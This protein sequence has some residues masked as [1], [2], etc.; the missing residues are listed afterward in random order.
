[1]VKLD[2]ADASSG[3][4]DQDR[5][6][7]FIIIDN[8]EIG[9]LGPYRIIGKLAGDA[10]NTIYLAQDP[11]TKSTVTIKALSF[12][13]GVQP[14]KCTGALTEF[15]Y[16][17]CISPSLNH[18]FII[19][20]VDIGHDGTTPYIVSEYV[21]G[22]SLTTHLARHLKLTPLSTVKYLDQI[23][24]A[25][26]FAHVKGINHLNLSPSKILIDKNDNAFVFDFGVSEL[27]KLIIGPQGDDPLHD[28]KRELSY[29]APEQ[30]VGGRQGDFKSDLFSFAAIAFEC[31]SG[32]K[33]FGGEGSDEIVR[34]LTV[35]PTPV[36]SVLCPD[37]PPDLDPV[38]RQALAVSPED[39]YP[40][41]LD[42]TLAVSRVLHDETE[43]ISL[44]PR[45]GR[46]TAPLPEGADSRAQRPVNLFKSAPGGGQ[47]A[48]AQA[49]VSPW[50]YLSHIQPGQYKDHEEQARSAHRPGSIF[51]RWVAGY[52]EMPT[53]KGEMSLRRSR[54]AFRQFA[55]LILG[56]IAAGVFGYQLYL[57]RSGPAA[58]MSSLASEPQVR[59]I[60]L[61]EQPLITPA[62]EP[63]PG[64]DAV[65]ILNNRQL[66]G[67]LLGEG[68]EASDKRIIDALHEAERR[69][70]ANLVDACALALK[71]HSAKVRQ[72]ILGVVVGLGDKRIVQYITPLLEDG[73]AAIRSRAIEVLGVLGDKRPLNYLILRYLSEADPAIK[74][75]FYDAIEKISG[76]AM[77]ETQMKNRLKAG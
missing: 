27:L 7:D 34:A 1:M 3:E 25:I 70:V 72:E 64:N 45:R 48:A 35:G 6:S 60:A 4:S 33:A 51:S 17:M 74:K 66:F 26:D 69:K 56:S 20:I 8:S 44:E 18:P 30:L 55:F 57:G 73:D 16:R 71:K 37:L 36:I 23:A 38:F 62:F 59:E 76:Y 58:K 46:L 41:A 61:A 54:K 9:H 42:F 21:E 29:R 40:T 75:S 39:R 11:K 52:E 14:E 77:T 15:K 13:S 67:I 43:R 31:L 49:G 22:E 10:F 65:E 50:A 12:L 5:P 68:G 63:A 19:R 32:I 28:Q 53:V 24:A 2:S 47:T